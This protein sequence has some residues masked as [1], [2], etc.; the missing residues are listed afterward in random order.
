[1]PCRWKAPSRVRRFIRA[2]VPGQLRI[3]YLLAVTV[4]ADTGEE[5]LYG[6]DPDEEHAAMADRKIVVRLAYDDEAKVWWTESS[7][8]F[9]VNAEAGTLDEMRAKLP[10]VV[11]DMIEANE[12]DLLSSNVE[13]EIVVPTPLPAAA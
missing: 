10:Q 13:L 2:T 5:V 9:G 7:T 8:L 11:V 12:P 1:M 3:I 6:H 4:A